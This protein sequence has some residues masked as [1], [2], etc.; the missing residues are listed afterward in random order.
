MPVYSINTITSA[1]KGTFLQL[2]NSNATIEQISI[3]SRRVIQPSATLFF[4][5]QTERRDGQTFIK[6]CYDKG[7]RNFIVHR[8]LDFAAFKEA[9][10]ILVDDTLKALHLLA[11]FHRRQFS[12][13]VIGITGSNGK[14]IVKEWLYQLLGDAYRIVRSPKSYNSQ[15]GVPLSVW[16][17]NS[18][19]TLALFEAGVSQKAEMQQLE[20]MIE[21]TIGVLT[22]LG[23]AH[24]QGFNSNQEKLA[25]KTLLFQNV[26]TII[27]PPEQIE[28][29]KPHLPGKEMITWGHSSTD[30]LKIVSEERETASTKITL[31]WKE[32][33]F[34]VVIPF[35]D[36]ASVHNALT[37]ICVCL[38]LQMNVEHLQQK[39]LQLQPI[40]LRLEIKKG[41][42]HCTL[43]N[44]SYSADLSSFEI[45]LNLLQQQHQH[46]N[47]TIILS[48]F[49]VTEKK[50]EETCSLLAA[51]MLQHGVQKIITV[52]PATKKFMSR[53]LPASVQWI[54]FLSVDELL[55]HIPL[56]SLHNEAVLIKGARS[57]ELERLMPV[58]EQKV[59]QTVLEINLSAIAHNLKLI[60]E[61]LQPGVKMM[62]MVKAFSYG[63]GSYEIAN[64]LQYHGADYL[65]VAF[66]DEG[67]ELRKAGIQL[68]IMVMNPE[69]ITFDAMI[70]HNLEPELYS[71]HSLN[72]FSA[73]LTKEGLSNYPVH[74]KLDTGMH[75]LG[76][77]N[78]ELEE[79]CSVIQKH[80]SLTIQSV[81]SHL[82][83]SEDPAED[84]FTQQQAKQFEEACAYIKQQT[85]QTF[86]RHL[87]N[88]SGIF[89][90]PKLE[91]EMV[92]LG[93][94]M[95]GITSAQTNLF[96]EEA[97][98]LKT[99]I[100][101]IKHLQPGD[102]VG[103]NRKGTITRPS[104]IA[105]VRIGYAD[106][107]PRSLSNGVG[108]M[109]VNGKTVP[110]IGTVCMDMTMLD[111]TGVDNV[112]EGDEVLVFGK[113]LSIHK[114]A[115]QAGTIPYEIMTGIGQRVKRVY[116]EE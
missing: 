58:L 112:N 114:L 39:L 97:L 31:S 49:P 16:Q 86:F 2:A 62:G 48:D 106:G 89:R 5:L 70:E 50:Q 21:P 27:Y 60:R 17:M 4:A 37:C 79:L 113:L 25:E 10:F 45:A 88:T 9:N 82:A 20:Q 69:A 40:S 99:T 110:V 38:H 36:E 44:D 74:L 108:L 80:Q 24:Q 11:A 28:N 65:A 94:G 101:Q 33:S 7:V 96:L 68:P 41:I 84:S 72:A 90:H 15:V 53:F 47:K 42:Q 56:L 91:Y 98:T 1:V 14:T 104:V 64:L 66:T 34:E 77:T 13:P 73:F 100:A 22:Y 109:L 83:A 95:Y 29:T 35:A 59:H 6:Q 75:R 30:T 32:I 55:Q 57:F 54:S 85:G 92:R 19:H 67:V 107:Y 116:Y 63:S 23:D 46:A 76:F 115:K 102:T 78:E 81:F 12:I 87:G 103:Y 71:F 52:G 26:N 8:Q 51:H 61:Q 93:I 105:T 43:I 111:I 3:D 18:D